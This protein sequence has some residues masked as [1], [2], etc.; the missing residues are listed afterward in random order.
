MATMTAKSISKILDEFRSAGI[1]HRVGTRNGEPLYEMT[2]R[3]C[4]IAKGITA[5]IDE[6][7]QR[8]KDPTRSKEFKER[9][10]ALMASLQEA[11]KMYGVVDSYVWKKYFL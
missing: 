1:L 11:D 4:E 7:S 8:Y 6:L 10:N 3:G 2:P 5:I 9:V